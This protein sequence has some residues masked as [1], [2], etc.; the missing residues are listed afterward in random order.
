MSLSEKDLVDLVLAGLRS[1]YKE[2]LDGLGFYFLNQ[3]QVRVLGQ[4]SKF[5]KEKDTYKSHHS[6]THIVEYDSDSSDDEDKK[7]YATEFVCLLRPNHILVHLLS[8][9]KKIGKKR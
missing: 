2:K 9:L 4:E 8:R 7:V 3:L 6:N 5:K 1:N